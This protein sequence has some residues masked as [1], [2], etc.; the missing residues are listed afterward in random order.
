MVKLFA[1]AFANSSASLFSDLGVWRRVNPLNLR[2]SP[3]TIVKYFAS[4]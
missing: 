1:A 2:S 4:S 3:L